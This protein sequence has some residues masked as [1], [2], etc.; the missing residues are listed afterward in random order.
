MQEPSGRANELAKQVR[1]VTRVFGRD[2]ADT[3]ENLART[4]R[5]VAHV[6]DRRRDD[7]EHACLSRYKMSLPDRTCYNCRGAAG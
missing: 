6:A 3:G 4:G 5:N 1:A 7:I 2:R